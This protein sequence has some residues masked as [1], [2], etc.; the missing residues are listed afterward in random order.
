MQIAY[1]IAYTSWEFSFLGREQRCESCVG[2]FNANL[3]KWN[4]VH[5]LALLLGWHVDEV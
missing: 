5:T 4:P 2:K 3:K 1:T